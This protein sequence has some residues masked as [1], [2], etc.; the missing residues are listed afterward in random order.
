M[1]I[2]SLINSFCQFS[3]DGDFIYFTAGDHARV[4]VYVLPIPA[5]PE[6]STTDPKLSSKYLTPVPLLED[7]AS[8]GLQT[9]SNGRVLVS[10]SSLTSPNDVFL[11]RGLDAL[12]TEIAQTEGKVKFN[13]SVAQIT[14]FTDLG[15][16]KLSKGE[17]FWFKGAEDHD[18]HGWI[19][20]PKGWKE[21]EKKAYPVVLLIH[22]GMTSLR[23]VV[24]DRM[25]MCRDR[26]S[27]C[28]G[29]PM[30]NPLEPEWYTLHFCFGHL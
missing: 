29:R 5:T 19:V 18:V 23:S 15:D 27:K 8:S 4:K 17:E 26:P 22:G 2:D 25:L 6:K 7:G 28:L 1:C 24:I 3:K 12:Q 13:G 30:V 14:S 20:K 10:K 9:L 16:K 21:G 11:I